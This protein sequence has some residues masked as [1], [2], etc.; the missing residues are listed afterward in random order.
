MTQVSSLRISPLFWILCRPKILLLQG[1]DAKTEAHQL[2]LVHIAAGE[3][4]IQ[5]TPTEQLDLLLLHDR[6]LVLL[7]SAAEFQLGFAL[8][9]IREQM[10]AAI[11]GHFAI[12]SL[13]DRRCLPPL[14][15][16]GFLDLLRR[17][18]LLLLLH[19]NNVVAGAFLD[20]ASDSSEVASRSSSSSFLL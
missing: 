16:L 18:R 20:S 3:A 7:K 14:L 11:L 8:L 9:H 2:E 1:I 15:R 5:P 13:R 10:P 6:P 17:L 12:T 4:G 19:F